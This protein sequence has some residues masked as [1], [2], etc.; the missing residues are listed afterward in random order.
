ADT[1]PPLWDEPWS[2]KLHHSPGHDRSNPDWRSRFLRHPARKGFIFGERSLPD[3][4]MEILS[5][6]GIR[7]IVVPDAG[8]SMGLENP[9]GL[10]QAIADASW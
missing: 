7:V 5:S 6:Q 1:H 2:S 9:H 10:A 4:D 3:P 8:H